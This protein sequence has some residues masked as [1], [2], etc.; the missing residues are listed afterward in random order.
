MAAEALREPALAAYCVA[1]GKSEASI[2]KAEGHDNRD[3]LLAWARRNIIFAGDY[4]THRAVKAISD[5]FEHGYK[6][7][8]EV[9]AVSSLLCDR[10]FGLL[11]HAITD[12]LDLDE[13]ARSRL[14]TDFAIPADTKSLRKR[15]RG[16]LIGEAEDIAAP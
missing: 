5:A 4:Q 15:I 8:D 12:L 16:T 3:H 14:L 7:V 6:T 9:R 13:I 2:M 10:A 1:T 11:R